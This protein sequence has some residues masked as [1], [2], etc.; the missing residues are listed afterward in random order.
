MGVR[1]EC[2]CHIYEAMR[3]TLRELKDVI[4]QA[5]DERAHSEEFEKHLE[6]Q[7]QAKTK[8]LSVA[9]SRIKSNFMTVIETLRLSKSKFAQERARKLEE[10]LP[11]LFGFVKSSI[12]QL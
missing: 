8:E 4:R 5:L 3:V 7:K 10:A 11:G 1:T 2:M 6:A 9:L 12:D